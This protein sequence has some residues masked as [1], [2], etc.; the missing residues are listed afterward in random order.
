MLQTIRFECMCARQMFW[1]NKI[2]SFVHSVHKGSVFA[3]VAHSSCRE[4]L[5]C[6]CVCVWGKKHTPEVG[7][8][9]LH[10]CS[11]ATEKSP[12]S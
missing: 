5:Q 7:L 4:I 12:S 10:V 1:L 9:F 11:P 6:V 2:S 3:N 8:A